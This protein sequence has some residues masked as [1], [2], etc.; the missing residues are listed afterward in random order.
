MEGNTEV[1]SAKFLEENM[2]E[3]PEEKMEKK[4]LV[5]DFNGLFVK[6]VYYPKKEDSRETLA[7]Y[8]EYHDV[9]N[10]RFFIHP[11]TRSFIEKLK[12][13][14]KY[15]FAIWSSTT[16]T[17]VNSVLDIVF[18][19]HKKDNLFKFVWTR[20][21]CVKDK[22]G[23]HPWSTIKPLNKITKKY[24]NYTQ[25]N[26]IIVD[27]D[28]NKVKMNKNYIIYSMDKD[29]NLNFDYIFQELQNL[30]LNENIEKLNI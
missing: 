24:K 18:P 23:E 12:K 25:D 13:D 21:H 19:N 16:A 5:L 4:L 22:N 28:F 9:Y 8:E 20:E 2:E 11:F 14:D 26:M 10:M 7:N 27:D 6:K 17:Y 29:E 1:I 3:K 15:D 30:E